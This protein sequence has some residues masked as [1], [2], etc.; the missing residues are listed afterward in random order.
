MSTQILFPEDTIL[1]TKNFNFGQ[2]WEIPIPAF[3]I[4]GAQDKTK[5]SVQDFTDDELTE[6]ILNIKKIRIAMTKVLSI[7]DVYFFQNEDTEHGFH[8]WIFPRYEWME[9]FGRKIESVR[10][11]INYAQ[12]HMDTDLNLK[13]VKGVAKK[14]KEYLDQS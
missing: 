7:K 12:Q 3:F 4:A 8:V 6:L 1:V 9:Q 10:T 13:E 2:D 14:V 11:I 5:R